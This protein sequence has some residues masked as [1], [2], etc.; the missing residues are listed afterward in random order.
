MWEEG[1]SLPTLCYNYLFQQSKVDV[2]P[3]DFV[4]LKGGYI[5]GVEVEVV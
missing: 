2:S 4:G 3:N 5:W 1:T